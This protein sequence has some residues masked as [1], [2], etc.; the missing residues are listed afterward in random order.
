MTSSDQ[1]DTGD[2]AARVYLYPSE[3]PALL[4]CRDVPLAWRITYALAAY[5]GLRAGELAALRWS[6]VDDGVVRL[7]RALDRS[8]G[9]TKVPKSKETRNVPVEPT[10]A[11]LLELVRRAP[12]SLVVTQSLGQKGLGTLLRD[13]LIV[14]SLK[15]AS[16]YTR[17]PGERPITFHDLRAT[18]LTWMALR[19][20]APQTIQQ[21]AGHSSYTT[22]QGYV[23]EAE[24]IGF[25][26][27]PFP[28]MPSVFL[29]EIK[30]AQREAQSPKHA[31]KPR[32]KMEPTMGFEVTG[33]ATKS[34]TL[35]RLGLNEAVE[36]RRAKAGPGVAR[37]RPDTLAPFVAT[38]ELWELGATGTAGES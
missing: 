32:R 24:T 23:R 18:A 21:R 35:E 37:A 26:G 36:A 6:D 34:G 31:V 12:E 22:T 14:A 20:D 16:L 30:E 5:T 38:L 29:S 25:V 8:S 27:V 13:H 17:G 11:P 7:R 19:G 33:N 1:P 4:A 10:L 3:M 28:P 15:R 9:E 2:S